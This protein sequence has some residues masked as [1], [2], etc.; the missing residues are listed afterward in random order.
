MSRFSVATCSLASRAAASATAFLISL[1]E[2]NPAAAEQ[3]VLTKASSIAWPAWRDA[4]RSCVSAVVRSAVSLASDA[5][6]VAKSRSSAFLRAVVSASCSSSA[7]R[8]A[9]YAHRRRKCSP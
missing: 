5:W 9:D 7:A 1:Q 6:T 2:R 3:G 4:H 8:R